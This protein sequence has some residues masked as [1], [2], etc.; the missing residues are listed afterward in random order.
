MFL[1]FFPPFSIHNNYRERIQLSRFQW[2]SK[3]LKKK[4]KE[5]KTSESAFALYGEPYSFWFIDESNLYYVYF[6]SSNAFTLYA[7]FFW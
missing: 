3:I 4:K 1:V 6:E 2:H 7:L 5:M